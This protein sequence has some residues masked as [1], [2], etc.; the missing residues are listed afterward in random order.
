MDAAMVDLVDQEPVE[1]PPGLL[2]PP[3]HQALGP[4]VAPAAIRLDRDQL[5]IEEGQDGPAWAVVP[6]LPFLR[7]YPVT[8]PCNSRYLNGTGFFD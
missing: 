1:P 3:Q 4:G 7:G 2:V 6:A 8:F 5:H